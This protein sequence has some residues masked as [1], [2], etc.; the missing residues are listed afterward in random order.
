MIAQGGLLVAVKVLR[1]DQTGVFLQG[2]ASAII[3]EWASP[4]TNIIYYL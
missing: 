2:A 1:L 4:G 3:K